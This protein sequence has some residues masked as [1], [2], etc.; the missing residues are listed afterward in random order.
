VQ[1]SVEQLIVRLKAMHDMAIE[2]H[3]LRNQYSELSGME[4]DKIKCRELIA[5]IQALALGIA[6]DKS[7]TDIITEMDSWKE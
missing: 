1:H 6:N 3:R 5:D 7:G 2:V 4:Y